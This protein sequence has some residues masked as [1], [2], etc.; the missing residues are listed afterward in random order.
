VAYEGL[1]PMLRAEVLVRDRRRCRWC[2]ATNQ[3]LDLHH[4]VYRRSAA[5]DH[6]DNLVALCRAHH[7]FVHGI[8]NTAGRTITK[9]VAQKVLFE[10]IATPG[11]TG[12]ALWRRYERQWRLEGRC[13][14][15]GEKR[16]ECLECSR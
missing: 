8:P 7:R 4:I 9:Q 3:P 12:A 15:H 10:V 16:D 5:D 2:G 11:L 14:P 1:D 13:L 6:V